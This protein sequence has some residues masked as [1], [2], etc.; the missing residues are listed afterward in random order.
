[1]GEGIRHVGGGQSD[2]EA[3]MLYRLRRVAMNR[4]LKRLA[5]PS[6]P[7][8]FELGSGCG[9]WAGFL[10]EKGVREYVG[11]D[12]SP[13][14]VARLSSAFP[15]YKFWSMDAAASGWD[16]IRQQAPYDLGL[17]IDVLYHIVDDAAWDL[18]L[19]ELCRVTRHAVI[20]VDYFYEQPREPSSHVK[21]RSA[22][23]YVDVLARHDFRVAWIQPV[24]H[25]HNRII[26]GPW[27]DQNRVFSRCLRVARSSR[28]GLW[29]LTALDLLA[30]KL[31]RPMSPLC[32]ARMLAATRG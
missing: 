30:T 10:A 21:H 23:M 26:G 4:V 17:A 22:Q 9:F 7:R 16:H 5:L 19:G 13:T 1:M 32:K 14:A 12:L 31:A 20:L 28:A 2:Y 8:V 27:A 6:P 3:R 29:C 15:Q 18:N 24:F 25:L 11:S